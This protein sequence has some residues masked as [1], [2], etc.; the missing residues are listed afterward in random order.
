[1][2]LKKI[3]EKLHSKYDFNMNTKVLIFLL[4]LS[5]VLNF[6]LVI[7]SDTVI[8]YLIKD[9]KVSLKDKSEKQENSDLINTKLSALDNKKLLKT[10][11]RENKEIKKKDLTSKSKIKKAIEVDNFLELEDYLDDSFHHHPE[12]ILQ[13]KKIISSY[14]KKT[15]EIYT[16]S[17]KKQE[18]KYGNKQDTIYY[19]VSPEDAMELARE[20]QLARLKLMKL[21]GRKKFSKFLDWVHYH[22]QEVARENYQHQNWIDI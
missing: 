8:N 17:A 6:M 13:I 9:N 7:S 10:F 5:L 21:F 12:K 20:K 1:M 19:S 3:A 18:K 2:I 16:L 11:F 15:D 4:S 22:N 14:A